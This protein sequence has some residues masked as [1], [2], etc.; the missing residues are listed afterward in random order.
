MP[1]AGRQMSSGTCRFAVGYPRSRARL[2]PSTTTPRTSYGRP[3]I[4]FAASSDPRATP[5]GSPSTTHDRPR[6]ERCDRRRRP[7]RCRPPRSP[8]RPRPSFEQRDVAPALMTEVEVLTHHDDLGIEAVDQHLAHEVLRGFL[9]ARPR[10]SGSRTRS[11][12]RSGR[13]ARVSDPDRS[14]TAAPSQVGP[15]PPDA[16]R[17]SRPQS[18]AL[19]RGRG[20]ARGRSP[21]GVH[22]G[23]RRRHRW[24]PRCRS[25]VRG[26][27]RRHE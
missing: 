22:D 11:R 4:V 26:T 21:L 2:S 27:T 5:H 24:S 17:R 13:A 14:A 10:R 7:A 3:S 20:S 23:H 15:P 8:K 1:S 19:G 18:G 6:R 12:H 9:R 16:G 25:P